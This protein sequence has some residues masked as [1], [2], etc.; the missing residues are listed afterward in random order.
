[1][2]RLWFGV[3]LLVLFLALGLWSMGFLESVREPMVAALETAAQA[4]LSGKTAEGTE[5]A[6][7]ATRLWKEKEKLLAA[8]TPHAMMEEMGGLF[9]RLGV[10]AQGE[11]W[12][13]FAACC[14]QLAQWMEALAEDQGCGWWSLL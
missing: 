3:A 11:E 14:R 13:A 12:T 2:N 4:A 9:A 7:E 6:A 1:M 10:Y 5:K 8:V